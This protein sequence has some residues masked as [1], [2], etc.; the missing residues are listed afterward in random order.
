MTLGLDM[1]NSEWLKSYLGAGFCVLGRCCACP[2]GVIVVGQV[3]NKVATSTAHDHVFSCFSAYGLVMQ[4]VYM[5]VFCAVAELA[6]IFV[7][8]EEFLA[9]DLPSF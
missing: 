4:V 9:F 5:K 3:F 1:F 8:I 7:I 6:S 2:L